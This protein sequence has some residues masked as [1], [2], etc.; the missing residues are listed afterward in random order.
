MA[1]TANRPWAWRQDFATGALLALIS[2]VSFVAR[3]AGQV[4]SREAANKGSEL[5][6]IPSNPLAVVHI[7]L[8]DLRNGDL[9]KNIGKQ[10]PKE[11]ALLRQQTIKR[12]G[13]PFEEIDRLTLVWLSPKD[14]YP[15]VFV[16]A[17]KPYDREKVLA[18][19][20][21]E[22]QEHR[23]KDKGY[24][25]SKKEDRLALRFIN[26]RL[27]LHGMVEDL[28]QALLQAPAPPEEALSAVMQSAEQKH[29]VVAGLRIPDVAT[30]LAKEGLA[31]N[32]RPERL[33]E[34]LARSFLPLLDT[35]FLALAVDVKDQ[36]DVRVQLGFPTEKQ[37][38]EA[39]WPARDGAA[40]ARLLLASAFD[41]AATEPLFAKFVP[42]R[43][44][45]ETSL[46][47]IK[48]EQE[49]SKIQIA[50][51]F[52]GDAQLLTGSVPNLVEAT[53]RL[54]QA[55]GMHQSANN[56]KQIALAFHNY[57][58]TY[59]SFPAAAIYS[60][61]GKPLLSWR[62]AILPYLEQ[63]GLYRQFKLDEPWDS[64]HNK[65]LL[66]RMPP[67]YAAPVAGSRPPVAAGKNP[68]QTDTY[69]QGFVGESAVFEGK[70]G[71]RITEI[72]DGTSNTLLMV[73]AGEPVPWTK[74][75][76]LPFDPKKPLPKLGGVF[77][78]IFYAAFCDGSVRGL[79]KKMDE[80]T[81]RALITRNGG[82]VVDSSTF[83]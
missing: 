53:V 56:L 13:L 25:A 7:R 35:R 59:G 2:A 72:T 68:A 69:Y 9:G 1:Q 52:A 12:L 14:W 22:H 17:A 45:V 47:T 33:D 19:V 20:L 63:D 42:L 44:E 36:I 79:K 80:R 37:A 54:Q 78:E 74:P 83:D 11:L 49:G 5:A 60:K 51:R 71:V 26:D 50:L 77:P 41:Q 58:D 4:D 23:Q 67:V 82:E 64:A 34:V 18:T 43:K 66:E 15:L 31:R 40:L 3:S 6:Q 76:D 39:L 81:L 21:P 38:Q 75:E 28:V 27:Y 46:R 16:S 24:Y 10:L 70:D 73:E 8:A 57:H 29:D 48:V 65:R 62:V 55:Q 61:D 30:A 32:Q